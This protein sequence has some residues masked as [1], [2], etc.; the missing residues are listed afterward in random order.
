[1]FEQLLSFYNEYFKAAI[2]SAFTPAVIT[3]AGFIVAII[4]TTLRLKL[5]SISISTSLVIT[6]VSLNFLFSALIMEY[7][8]EFLKTHDSKGGIQNIYL[9]FTFYNV[10]FVLI[11]GKLQT[12]LFYNYS[13]LFFCVAAQLTLMSAFHFL[14]WFKLVILDFQMEYS[15]LH[16]IYSSAVLYM[17]SVILISVLWPQITTTKARY[18]I[19][20]LSLVGR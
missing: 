19:N 2:G 7:V 3:N 18:F 9:F 10:L 8:I 5:K 11:M 15:F 14:L 6:L 20:P 17:T 16:P 13:P 4:I 12:K 1:M